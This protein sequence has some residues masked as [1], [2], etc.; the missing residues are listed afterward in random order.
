MK[1]RIIA[2]IGALTILL[3]ISITVLAAS[4]YNYS[5]TLTPPYGGS[6]KSTARQTVKT[7]DS[8]FVHPNV[9]ATP[10][11]YFLSPLQLSTTQATNIVS[12]ISTVGK[13]NFSYLSGY[14]GVGNSYCL[15]AYPTN[16]HFLEYRV[17]GTWSP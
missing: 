14:G 1:K 5:F 15:S 7:G 4:S 9:S 10:T 13:R 3:S 2:T 8:P 6:L 16:I 12:N 17:T 11:N